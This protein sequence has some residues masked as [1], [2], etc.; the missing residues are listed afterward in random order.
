MLKNS[1]LLGGLAV[2]ALMALGGCSMD[3]TGGSRVA[4]DVQTKATFAETRTLF[5]GSGETSG[6][7]DQRY[8]RRESLLRSGPHMTLDE[9][10]ALFS[11]KSYP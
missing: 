4:P 7:L 10:D 2:S 5:S 6:R 3:A 1:T 8:V 11:A 9:Y